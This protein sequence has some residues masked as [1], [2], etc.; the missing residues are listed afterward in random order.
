MKLFHVDPTRPR[1]IEMLV[2]LGALLGT[3]IAL[4]MPTLATAERYNRVVRYSLYAPLYGWADT[5]QEACNEIEKAFNAGN[6]AAGNHQ[7]LKSFHYSAPNNCI[8]EWEYDDKPGNGATNYPIDQSLQCPAQSTSVPGQD[9]C[10]SILDQTFAEATRPPSCSAVAADP[11]FGNPIYPLRGVK[12]EVVPLGIAVGPVDLRFIYDNGPMLQQS[13]LGPA[14]LSAVVLGSKVW[15]STVHRRLV[16]Q[17]GG[18]SV[19]VGR[20]GGEVS[21]FERI[22][23]V[24]VSQT[25]SGDRLTVGPSSI[26]FWDDGLQLMELYDPVGVLQKVSSTTGAFATFSYSD[27]ATPPTIAPVP[28]LLIAITDHNG[29]QVQ[30]RYE[31]PGRLKTIVDTD[32]AQTGV[33][34]DPILNLS[35]IVWS[36]S[37]KRKFDYSGTGFNWTLTGII[38]ES[39]SRYATF[40]Y[41]TSGRAISTEHAGGVDRYSVTYGLAPVKLMTEQ[42]DAGRDAVVRTLGW[43]AG[44][45][46]AVLRPN[47]QHVTDV[48][49]TVV[50]GRPVMTTNSQPAGAG[51]AAATS[52]QSFDAKGNV[53]QADDFNQHRTCYAYDA[54]NRVTAQVEGLDTS[55]NCASVLGGVLPAGARKLSTAWHPDWR[56][57]TK[58]SQPGRLTTTVYNG[59]PDPTSGNAIASCAPSG[60]LLPD[61]K[62]IVVACKRIDQATTDTSGVQGLSATPLAGVAARTTSWTYDAAGRVLTERDTSNVIT[63]TAEYH[64]DTTADHTIGDLKSTTNALGHPTLPVR[65]TRS[66]LPLEVV[67]AN[68]VSTVYAYDARRRQTSVTTAGNVTSYEYQPTGLLKKTT[69]AGGS[70]V[71]YEYDAAHRLTAVSDGLGNRVEYMLDANGNRTQEVIRDPQGALKRTMSRTFDAL[72]RA[73]QTTGRE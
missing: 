20:P 38:D 66:G 11:S 46:V 73:Q 56:L 10:I 60:A 41:D 44:A 4:L 27:A 55:A 63:M 68:G 62:P 45:G 15:R 16:V 54:A 70:V 22:G 47:G 67:D 13:G 1:R 71:N 12:R 17:G 61:G 24:M 40:G 23:G 36:D 53:V 9:A 33:L 37:Q 18:Q 52:S 65:Y 30:F 29:R 50:Q 43:Q 8:V 58:A 32:G 72:G 59:Q 39:D 21:G 25:G 35:A 3:A 7:F 31:G 2:R 14:Q 6:G 34:Y 42:F 57:Q 64:V 51:C 26:T 19:Q 69:Q 5:P 48:G 49:T 28:G